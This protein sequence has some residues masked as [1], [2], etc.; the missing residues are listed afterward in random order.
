RW[1]EGVVP[2]LHL[3]SAELEIAQRL[4]KALFERLPTIVL[5]SATLSTHGGEKG[6]FG[7][8]RKRLGIAEAE[9][10]IYT[11]PFNYKEQALLGIAA[12][13]PDP[14]HPSFIKE[15][16]ERIWQAIEI[17]KGG[18]FVLFTSY[19]MLRDCEKLLAERLHKKHYLLYCQGDENR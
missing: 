2:D 1:M 8:I 17:S 11:S 12:D 10:K 18:A 9:E 3:I 14:A 13:V 16:A 4:S 5:C 15:A 19:T 6:G 7:F